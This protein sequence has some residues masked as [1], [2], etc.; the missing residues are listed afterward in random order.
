MCMCPFVL[1][2]NT[3]HEGEASCKLFQLS[4]DRPSHHQELYNG[5]I[6]SFSSHLGGFSLSMQKIRCEILGIRGLWNLNQV[7][8]ENGI[9]SDCICGNRIPIITKKSISNKFA[10]QTRGI[11]SNVFHSWSFIPF[12]NHNSERYGK[13]FVMKL[14]EEVSALWKKICLLITK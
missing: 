2:A 1:L 14:T 7:I 11:I 5:G 12:M 10:V 6:L 9:M 4:A 13:W 8:P 3:V